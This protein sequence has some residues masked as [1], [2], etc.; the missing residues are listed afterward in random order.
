MSTTSLK[1]T[2]ELKRRAAAAA[3]SQGVTLHAFMLAAIESA[4]TGAEQR[5]SFVAEALAA[6]TA[7]LDSG[8]GYDADDVHAYLRNRVSG[9][10]SVRPK[11]KPWRG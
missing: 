5:A 3:Q 10:K 2:D 7:M 8:R 6:R 11:A 1:L 9:K 4:T